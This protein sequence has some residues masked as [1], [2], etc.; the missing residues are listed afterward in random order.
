M[1]RRHFGTVRRLPSGRYQARY[2]DEH[3]NRIAAPGNFQTK[4]EA[5]RWLSAVQTDMFRGVLLEPSAGQVPFSTWAEEWLTTK[6]GQRAAT[7]AR[8]RAAIVTHFEPLL[9]DMVLSSITPV[10]IRRVV[11]EMQARGLSAKSVRTYVGTLQAMFAAAVEA[12]VITR[13]PVRIRSLGLQRIVRRERPTLTAEQ[14]EALAAAVPDK[15][16]ALVLLAGVTGLRWGEAIGLR[17]GDVDLL[18]Q[19]VSVRQTVEE[20][21]GHAQIVAAT[22]T[23]ASRRRFSIP[24]LL[25]ERISAHVAEHRPDAGPDDLLFVGAKG[26]LL[27]RS[28]RARVFKPAVATAELPDDL[29][30]HGLRHVAASLLVAN[31]EHPKVIQAR[32]G[33]ADPSVS[34]GIY[35]H[36]SDDLDR[37]VGD[38]LGALFSTSP[39]PAAKH[40][41]E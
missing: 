32:L 9:G 4:T 2:S 26:G 16:A 35:A 14:L 17:L 1:G 28:F 6:P 18:R 20:V 24:T 11:L 41:E 15:Y 23:A 12:D 40:R 25:V 8:D 36:V 3:G 22:K 27:R 5:R 29:T 38:R 21:S 19:T 33:H 13:S 10:H 30:F 37:A 34:L 39:D 7:L 31:G